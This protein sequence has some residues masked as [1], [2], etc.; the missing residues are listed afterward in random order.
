[1]PA[2]GKPSEGDLMFKDLNNDGTVNDLDRTIIGKAVP[3]VVY[4]LNFE[5]YYKNFDFSIFFYG[6]QNFQVYNHLRA[7][8]EGFSTQDM[9]HNKLT[10]YANNYYRTDRPS[11]KY[12]RADLNNT[13]QNDRASTWFL[14][15]GSFLRLKDIQLGYSLPKW[16]MDNAGLSRTR[17]YVSATNLLTLTQYSGRDPEAPTVSGPL[18][19]GNDG[20]SYPIPRAIT[21]GLQVD[22]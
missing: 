16:M 12:I 4:S 5:A 9:G 7:G 10:D 13:N 17:I 22:F 19:P 20:G 1:M 21:F 2:T 15:E 11:T 3:D 6:M 18:T 8:I 14:E